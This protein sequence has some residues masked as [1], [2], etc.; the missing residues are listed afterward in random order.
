M[1]ASIVPEDVHRTVSA[2]EAVTE[3]ASVPLVKVSP[4][5]WGRPQGPHRFRGR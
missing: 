2:P 5:Y 3:A 4:P 1:E